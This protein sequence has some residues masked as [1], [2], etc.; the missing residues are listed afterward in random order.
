MG[1]AA[2]HGTIGLDSD[3]RLIDIREQFPRH[4]TVG[5]ASAV[6]ERLAR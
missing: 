4:D 5:D 1:A 3:R 2:Q 6:A